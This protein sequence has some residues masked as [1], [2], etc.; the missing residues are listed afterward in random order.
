MDSLAL[1]MPLNGAT[2]HE[3][4]KARSA[5][6]CTGDE[7]PVAVGTA[8]PTFLNDN[9][10]EHDEEMPKVP[11]RLLLDRLKHHQRRFEQ[12]FRDPVR[13]PFPVLALI[14]IL[15]KTVSRQDKNGSS[16]CV[17]G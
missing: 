2:T 12:V 4:W 8:P 5:R 1:L 16:S 15:T 7:P 14:L 3:K 9:E 6:R 17:V 10:H 11:W 13:L